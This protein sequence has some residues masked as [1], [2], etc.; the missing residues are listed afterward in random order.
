MWI[1]DF[2]EN[3]TESVGPVLFSAEYLICRH[4]QT[5]RRTDGR[6]DGLTDE[7]IWGGLGNLRFLQVKGYL[8]AYWRVYDILCTFVP[9]PKHPL[10]NK[11][12][13]MFGHHSHKRSEYFMT[14]KNPAVHLL[15]A[16]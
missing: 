15:T 7:L 1:H 14:T 6:T 12:F 13:D 11:L 5:D 4:V 8:F 2:E 10:A 9:G 3:S 16:M